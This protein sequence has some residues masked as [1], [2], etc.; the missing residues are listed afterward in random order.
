[1]ANK[2]AVL[3][4]AKSRIIVDLRGIP[5][6][7]S[8]EILIKN[9]AIAT[10]P[11]DYK[12]QDTGFIISTY[13]VV[14]GCDVCGE[15]QAVGDGVKRF[16][17]GD[18][19]AGFAGYLP[20]NDIDQGGFQEYT[21]VKSWA[22][23]KIPDGMSYEE[24]AILPL[25]VATAGVGIFSD[26][27]VSRPGGKRET[28]G[29]LVWGASSSVGSAAVQIAT[30]LGF[31]VVAVAS[32]QHHKYLM[33][34]GAMSCFDYKETEVVEK[35]VAATKIHGSEIKL[36]YDAVSDN[37]TW[38]QCC[39]I[40]EAFGGGRLCLTMAPSDESQKPS[41][42]TM[43]ATGALKAIKSPELGA[44]LFND[45]LEKSLFDKT[46]VPSPGIQIVEGGI[47]SVQRALDMHK[48]GVSGKKLVLQLA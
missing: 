26:L 38:P 33:S 27:Q 37:S 23:A 7:R 20:S 11:I 28:G 36:A 22:A 48:A 18:R 14:L 29:F 40:L 45:L 47:D 42:I 9:H 19:V 43:S 6:P 1:M 15:V 2:A 39:K 44:F 4:E 8:G 32:K 41:N 21:L 31:A 35:I 10:N 17:K 30:I 24:G 16:Q 3:P 13:P 46:Y 34:L 12:V 25:S 5:T